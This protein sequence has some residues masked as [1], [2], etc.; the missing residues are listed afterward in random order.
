MSKVRVLKVFVSVMLASLIAVTGFAATANAADISGWQNEVNEAIA[1][2][3]VYPRAA[4]RKEIEGNVKVEIQVDREGNIVAQN[5]KTSSG[6]DILDRE[7]PKLLKRVSPLPKPPA[8][9]ADSQLTFVVP[10]A[11]TI[12]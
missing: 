1:K 12:K 3:Q 2:K 7:V 5:I 11:W 4:L 10:L 8:D 6:E 9:A